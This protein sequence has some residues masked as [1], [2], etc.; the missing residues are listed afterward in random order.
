MSTILVSNTAAAV[1]EELCSSMERFFKPCRN[2]L[3]GLIFIFDRPVATT[4]SGL[5]DKYVQNP[6][7]YQQNCGLFLIGYL[8]LL[9]FATWCLI[10]T[11]LGVDDDAV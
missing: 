8:S 2:W 10:H 1:R 4:L 7:V 6:L 9:I 5:V 11:S 3:K